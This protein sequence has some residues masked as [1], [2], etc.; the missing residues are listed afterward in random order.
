[1]VT[2]ER[3]EEGCALSIGLYLVSLFVVTTIF[4]GKWGPTS[5][6]YAVRAGVAVLVVLFND[7]VHHGFRL[8]REGDHTATWSLS[9]IG[10]V[11][12]F[13]WM[14]WLR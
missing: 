7:Y 13:F 6:P 8:T 4:S 5:W 2:E 11:S 10:L 14:P 1:M 3:N 9:M 12:F